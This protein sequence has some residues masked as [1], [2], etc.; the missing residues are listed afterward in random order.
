MTGLNRDHSPLILDSLH[1]TIFTPCTRRMWF[2]QS[3][4]QIACSLVDTPSILL[5]YTVL[6]FFI[7]S[8]I[9]WIPFLYFETLKGCSLPPKWSLDFL[10]WYSRLL[11]SSFYILLR[12]YYI[13]SAHCSCIEIINLS[14]VPFMLQN[15]SQLFFYYEV[16]FS[17][18]V[19]GRRGESRWAISEQIEP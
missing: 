4:N 7:K 14:F 12:Y 10:P 6:T 3:Y 18:K 16:I 15:C 11:Q 13:W 9:S 2:G 8:S 1:I 17:T 5:W 19:C